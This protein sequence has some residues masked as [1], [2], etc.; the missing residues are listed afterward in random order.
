MLAHA[1]SPRQ[2]LLAHQPPADAVE[3]ARG[4]RPEALL[5]LQPRVAVERRAQ[6][7]LG[8]HATPDQLAGALDQDRGLAAPG[9][10]DHLDD[11]AA[12]VDRA[13]L[14]GVGFE[15]PTPGR[16]VGVELP[17]PGRGG[18]LGRGRRAIQA[19]GGIDRTLQRVGIGEVRI[20]E[21]LGREP[22]ETLLALDRDV[23]A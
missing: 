22:S 12:G 10:R 13:P 19:G 17:T 18:G 7:L 9:G 5:E 6:D 4:G 2:I 11:A 3:G 8:G 23:D 20:N 1:V 14:L 15:P 21:P 16:G